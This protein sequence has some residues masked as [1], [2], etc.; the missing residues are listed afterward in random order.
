[1]SRPFR[2]VTSTLLALALGM[3][4][5]PAA[6]QSPEELKAQQIAYAKEQFKEGEALLAAKNYAAAVA[7]YE[8][9]YRYAPELH[10]LNYNIGIASLEAGDCAKA[11]TS[12]QRFLDLVSTHDMRGEAQKKLMDIERSGCAAA[13]VTTT[14]VVTTPVVTEP[15]ERAPIETGAV[16]DR[17]LADPAKTGNEGLEGVDKYRFNG[18]MKGGLGLMAGGGALAIAGG[19]AW[20]ISFT[21]ANKL[22]DASSPSKTAFPGGDFSDEKIY[23]ADVANH[24]SRI[25][26]WALGPAGLALGIT[27]VALYFVGLKRCRAEGAALRGYGQRWAVA[28][29]SLREGAGVTAAIRFGNGT[30]SVSRRGGCG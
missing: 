14:P 23:K 2:T 24:G 22:A 12:L 5:A 8:E 10:V 30:S 16:K 4:A 29:T 9:A 19:V 20:I 1:M 28:P 18:L 15:E 25:A 6:A 17:E 13:P 11:R 26:A 7:K 27:G 21:T 3:H